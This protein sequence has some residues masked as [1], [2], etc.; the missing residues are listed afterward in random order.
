MATVLFS[1]DLARVQVL[2]LLLLLLLRVISARGR[3]RRQW[4]AGKVL[5]GGAVAVIISF[6]ALYRYRCG[7]GRVGILARHSVC[8]LRVRGGGGG[9]RA[10]GWA[11]KGGQRKERA[12]F[13]F[14]L[15]VWVWVV[16]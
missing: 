5:R 10:G 12:S 4:R 8:V 9:G 16:C 7:V 2:V 11:D 1:R 3:R 14:S 6:S 13:F 15:L